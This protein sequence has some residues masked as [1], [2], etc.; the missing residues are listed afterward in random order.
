MD[1]VFSIVRQ[2]YGRSSTD[3]VNDLDVNTGA[4]SILMNVTLQAAGRDLMENLRFTKNQ[5]LMSV[6]QFF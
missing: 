2:I 4:W 5:L 1:K 3:D 6:K